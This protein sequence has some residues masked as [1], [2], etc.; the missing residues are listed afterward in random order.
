MRFTPNFR[1]Q[2]SAARM[3]EIV[4]GLI[5]WLVSGLIQGTIEASRRLKDVDA[6][7]AEPHRVA[8]FSDE[9]AAG[10]AHLKDLLRRTVYESGSLMEARK[11]SIGRI[12]KLFNRWMESP[13]L[14]PVNYL[15]EAAGLPLYRVV[16]DYIAGMTD[17]FLL[18]TFSQ[19]F[20]YTG[21]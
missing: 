15:Q 18:R 6:V 2:V 10:S 3:H 16:C 14:L 12:E 9:T 7:R 17:G 8:C 13:E 1:V 19:L 20:P 4:R 11:D 5:N 21:V